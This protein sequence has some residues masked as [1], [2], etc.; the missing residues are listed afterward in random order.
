MFS[1][2]P[3][4]S[5]P[6]F[7]ITFG[8]IKKLQP[9]TETTEHSPDGGQLNSYVEPLDGPR[10]DVMH[11]TILLGVLANQQFSWFKERKKKAPLCSRFCN[12]Y[13]YTIYP[14]MFFDSSLCI[15]ASRHLIL[16]AFLSDKHSHFSW[17]GMPLF[18]DSLPVITSSSGSFSRRSLERKHR[19]N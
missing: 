8:C 19:C 9:N 10:V 4:P 2:G 5:A 6:V 17:L 14:E 13:S 1:E 11:L 7:K 3:S 18:L 16:M 12:I 15:Y